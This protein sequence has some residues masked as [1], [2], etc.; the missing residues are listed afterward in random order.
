MEKY[1]MARLDP[2][3]SL[4]SKKVLIESASPDIL[5]DW[6]R[7]VKGVVDSEDLPLSITREKMQDTKLLRQI[8]EAL[9]RRIIR[10][11][12]EMARKDRE[13]YNQYF[14]EFGGFLKEGVCTDYNSKTAIA[15]L[16]RFQSNKLDDT[17][18]TSLDEYISRCPPDQN[19]IYFLCAGSRESALASPYAESFKKNGTEFLILVNPIDEMVMSNLEKYNDKDLVGADRSSIN[20]DKEEEEKDDDSDVGLNKEKANDLIAFLKVKLGTKASDITVTN[21]LVDSPAIITDHESVAIRRMMQAVNEQSR[22]MLGKQKLA[23]NPKHPLMVSLE[24]VRQ[25]ND[26]VATLVAE[27]MFDNALVAAGLMDKSETM[28]PRLNNIMMALLTGAD[29]PSASASAEVETET[30][31]DSK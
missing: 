30:K 20:L 17:D 26:E 25:S 4:Y 16:L 2:S 9:T 23:I 6:L 10:Y 5:P 14:K 7:F 1:G 31:D 12:D 28:L 29:A 18:L 8:N 15:K 21:R 24:S 22:G 27:Q 11:L 19:Q 3:V 13:G